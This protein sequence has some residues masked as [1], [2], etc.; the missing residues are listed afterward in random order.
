M[1]EHKHS[2]EMQPYNDKQ[3]L[4]SRNFFAGFKNKDWIILTCPPK[5][6]GQTFVEM[7]IVFVLPSTTYLVGMLIYMTI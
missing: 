1:A 7:Q 6:H 5:T 3:K 4:L 2:C